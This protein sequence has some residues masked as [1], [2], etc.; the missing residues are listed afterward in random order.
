[1]QKQ[2][3]LDTYDDFDTESPISR[4][5]IKPSSLS[6]GKIAKPK[7]P[8]IKF[9]K[10]EAPNLPIPSSSKPIKACKVP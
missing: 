3:I 9:T 8:I 2:V 1:M 5:N 6:R 7:T 4:T 10:H